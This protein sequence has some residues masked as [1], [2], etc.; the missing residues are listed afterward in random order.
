MC[1]LCVKEMERN[2]G[3]FFGLKSNVLYKKHIIYH[4]QDV[5]CSAFFFY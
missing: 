1:V 2:S 4:K 3:H 5:K